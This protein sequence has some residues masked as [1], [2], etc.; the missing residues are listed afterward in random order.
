MRWTLGDGT[1]PY[2]DPVRLPQAPDAHPLPNQFFLNLYRGGAAR[3]RA[4]EA[5]EHTAQVPYDEREAREGR[6][7]QADL[8][9]LYCSPTMELGVD[10]SALNVGHRRNVPPTPAHHAQPSGRAG[11]S[12]QP[13]LVSTYSAADRRVGK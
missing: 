5:R 11:P 8:P 3:F 6:F 1:K 7:R 13:A 10:S 4:L 2:L 12:G 9:I